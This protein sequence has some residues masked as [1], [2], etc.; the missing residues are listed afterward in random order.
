MKN[1]RLKISAPAADTAK[2]KPVP[3]RRNRRRKNTR[4]QHRAARRKPPSL[5]L[6]RAS[7]GDLAE[8][9]T[10]ER[11][12]FRS[13]RIG[14]RNL[15]RWILGER[16][17]VLTASAH[18]TI[19]GYVAV[20]FR[21]TTG[22]LARIPSIAVRRG[23]RGLGIGTA[24]MKRAEKAATGAGRTRIRLEVRLSTR[25]AVALYRALGYRKLRDLPAYY[26]DGGDAMRMEKTLR[27][28]QGG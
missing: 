15:R 20:Q 21:G 5:R 3:S 4:P 12:S 16:S 24:L 28:R 2:G 13:D 10:I 14:P 17:T 7:I 22:D 27:R 23:A 19:F 8:L 11:Q 1:K 18:G 26:A 25:R 9:L 6:R